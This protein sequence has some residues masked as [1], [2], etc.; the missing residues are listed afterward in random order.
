MLKQISENKKLRKDC[1]KEGSNKGK[2]GGISNPSKLG[3]SARDTRLRKVC[4]NFP[5][6]QL[7]ISQPHSTCHTTVATLDVA[8]LQLQAC[9]T[10]VTTL[11]LLACHTA[12]CHT[13]RCHTVVTT[14]QLLHPSYHTTVATP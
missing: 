4:S 2:I 11:Q 12:S 6:W 3:N 13:G 1:K 10:V 7:Y 14:L 5:L 9:Y 8:T